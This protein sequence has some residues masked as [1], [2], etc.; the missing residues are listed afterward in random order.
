MTYT[1]GYVVACCTECPGALGL[2]LVPDGALSSIPV[3]AGAVGD[4]V[5]TAPRALLDRSHGRFCHR[6]RMFGDGICPRC[7]GESTATIEVCDDHDGGE[8]PCSACGVTMPAVVRTTCRVCA[9]GG[10]APGATVV[11]HRTPFREALAAAGVDRLGY[12]AFATM[13]RWPATVTDADGDPAL[14]YDL[15]TVGGDVVVDGDLDIAVE[16][17]A[18][19]Q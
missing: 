1:G 10:I 2:D 9:E 17:V 19:G 7:G 5:E 14:R 12:D 6:A 15:P 8:E 16:A 18:D 3:P 11:S 4:A 13:L